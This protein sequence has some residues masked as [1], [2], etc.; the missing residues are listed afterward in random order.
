[1]KTPSPRDFADYWRKHYQKASLQKNGK[2]KFCLDYSNERVQAQTFGL[3]LEAA[4]PFKGRRCLDLGCGWGQLSLAAQRMGAEVVGM[5]LTREAI[6]TL[7]K[8]YPE[9]KWIAGSFND[10]ALLKPRDLFDVILAVEVLQYLP[11]KGMLR[12]LWKHLKPGGR[13]VGVIP[14]ADCPIVQKPIRRFH[15]YFAAVTKE[16]I[17][18]ECGELPDLETWAIRGLFFG[19]D[20]RIVPYQT[21]PWR[22]GK[23]PMSP[24]PNRFIF[25]ALRKG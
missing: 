14:N 13:L 24:E 7:R 11:F 2:P 8:D 5:D 20:Q 12:Y 1:M 9:V 23:A 19:E 16:E 25:V 6:A 17:M 4:G 3:V 21:T 18:A 22:R 15:G 10:P